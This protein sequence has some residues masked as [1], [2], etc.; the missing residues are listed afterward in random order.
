MHDEVEH[1]FDLGGAE[2]P[3]ASTRLGARLE[4]EDGVG[5]HVVDT[6]RADLRV[7]AVFGAV[8]GIEEP[9]QAVHVLDTP[10]S[11]LAVAAVGT[12]LQVVFVA[13]HVPVS[14]VDHV[15][16][17]K[18]VALDPAADGPLQ[19]DPERPVLDRDGA[20][21]VR[22]VTAGVKVVVA[23]AEQHLRH[24]RVG[25]PQTAVSIQEEIVLDALRDQDEARLVL[26]V[27]GG[28]RHNRPECPPALDR[29]QE[30]PLPR[31]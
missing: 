23:V 18:A 10:R 16:D 14:D 20:L 1:V 26:V 5:T 22:P 17:R 19:E 21:V 28:G 2:L 30:E 6:R 12:A 9:I 11:R 3:L 29:C 27:V 31:A 7:L 24:D 8:G 25:Q 15:Q 13:G 4:V